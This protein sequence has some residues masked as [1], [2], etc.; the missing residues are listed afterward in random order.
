MAA[1]RRNLGT[2]RR[3]RL[4]ALLA[5]LVLLG[6]VGSCELPKPQLPSIGAADEGQRG[7]VRT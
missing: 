2:S 3:A 6:A 4:R 1:P 7:V 5:G